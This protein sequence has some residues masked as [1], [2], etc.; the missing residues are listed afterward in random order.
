MKSRSAPRPAKPSCRP[1]RQSIGSKLKGDLTLLDANGAALASQGEFDGGDPLLAWRFTSDGIY[2]IRVADD[3]A[4]GSPDHFYSLSMGQL[5][6]VTGVFPPSLATNAEAQVQLIGY[7]LADRIKSACNRSRRRIG[8]ALDAEKYRARRR[9]KILVTDG[10][11]LV[12]TE[13]NHTPGQAMPIPLPCTISG[14]INPDGRAGENADL[15]R[16]QAKAGEQLIIETDAARRGSPADTKIE[17][18]YGDGAPIER[19][20]LQAVRDSAITFRAIDSSQVEFRLENWVEMEL[21][22]YLYMQGEVCR[23]FRMPARAGLG[24]CI[25]TAAGKRRD[26]FDTSGT[27]HAL[28]GTVLH[29]SSRIPPGKSS[30]PTVADLPGVLRER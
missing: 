24:I 18:L 29:P 17:I 14:R 12:E 28:D 7:N 19:L 6:V 8:S 2:K 1:C 30:C 16:F 4:N 26:Y 22:Q 11:E 9:F 25:Y 3:T 13:S 27:A 23:I 15:F 10:P 20:Q 5:P 21:N